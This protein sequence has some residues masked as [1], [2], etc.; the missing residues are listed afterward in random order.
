[1]HHGIIKSALI[2]VAFLLSASL[3]FAANK[4]PEPSGAAADAAK[5]AVKG[6]K[7]EGKKAAVAAKI[8]LVVINSARK[9]ELKNL[10][11]NR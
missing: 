10:P 3:S 7:Q 5:L 8:K 2:A 9:A 6:S 4:K 1:M 11:N